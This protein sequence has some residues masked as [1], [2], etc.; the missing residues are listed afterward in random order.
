M[1]DMGNLFCNTSVKNTQNGV[2]CKSEKYNLQYTIPYLQCGRYD[3]NDQYLQH[4]CQD[5]TQTCLRN[6]AMSLELPSPEPVVDLGRPREWRNPSFQLFDTCPGSGATA[7][8]MAEMTVDFTNSCA[9]VMAEIS[10]RAGATANGD[11]WVDPHNRGH[12]KIL[13]T[14]GNLLKVQRWTAPYQYRDVQTFSMTASGTGCKVN[15]C[16]VSQG[17]SNND[18]GT[19]MCDMGNLFCNTSVKN[20][21]NGV[22]CKSVKYNLSY[23]IPYLQC[24]RYDGNNQYLQH[25][26]QD[27]TETCLRNQAALEA[28]A[29]GPFH[30]LKYIFSQ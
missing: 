5:V 18:G 20:T 14:E 26:C 4:N 22:A 8:T 7:H 2:A 28:E 13:A 15:A 30:V 1:C 23:N 6:A 16:S 29:E 3:G 11:G 12:Y 27:F 21:E 25:N 10:A 17:N 19:N 24:G 9:E